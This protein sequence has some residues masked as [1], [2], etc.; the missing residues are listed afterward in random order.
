MNAGRKNQAL[1]KHRSR[2][3]AHEN[4]NDAAQ[5]TRLPCVKTTRVVKM[6]SRSTTQHAAYMT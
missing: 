1:N 5:A 3:R 2:Q 4:R 6:Y